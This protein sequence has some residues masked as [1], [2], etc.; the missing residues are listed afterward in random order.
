MW[1]LAVDAET[2]GGVGKNVDSMVAEGG[3]ER[4]SDDGR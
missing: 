1:S 3:D 2:V 4:R